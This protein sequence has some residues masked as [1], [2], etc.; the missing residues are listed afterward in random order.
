MLGLILLWVDD[1]Q[2]LLIDERFNFNRDQRN[3][4][5]RNE[6][7]GNNIFQFRRWNTPHYHKI[8]GLFRNFKFWYWKII[9][10]VFWTFSIILHKHKNFNHQCN[11]SDMCFYCHIFS[12]F[13]NKYKLISILSCLIW[14]Q[15]DI[16]RLWYNLSNINIVQ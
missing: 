6:I 12:I 16:F 1:I 8:I 15:I 2:H 9:Q 13:Q 3:N 7:L 14:E 11:H 4:G 5:K 10:N